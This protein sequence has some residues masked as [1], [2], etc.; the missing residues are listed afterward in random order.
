ML[1]KRESHN[2]ETLRGEELK[3]MDLPLD[4]FERVSK[5]ISRSGFCSRRDAEVFV[6]DGRV[7]VDG[8]LVDIGAIASYSSLIEIDGKPISKILNTRL[9]IF[10]KPVGLITTHKDENGR[11]T[12]FESLPKSMPRVISVGRLD[13]YSE[14]LMLLTNDTGLCNYLERSSYRRTYR[15][16]IKGRLSDRD[17]LELREGITID[18]INYSSI[19]ACNEYSNNYTS[20]ISISLYEGKNR[21]IRNIMYEFGY[22]ILRL[23]RL[24]YGPFDLQ[25]LRSGEIQELPSS[26]IKNALTRDSLEN[27]CY[28]KFAD[29]KDIMDRVSLGRKEIFMDKKPLK[30]DI[31]QDFFA[32]LNRPKAFNSVFKN[33]KFVDRRNN[34]TQNRKEDYM[35][36]NIG[37]KIDE[38]DIEN[39]EN[40]D[41]LET[42]SDSE[43]F[44]PSSESNDS[45]ERQES[46]ERRFSDRAPRSDSGEERAPRRDFGDRPQRDGERRFPP[47]EGGDRAP[48]RDFG[49]RPQR[50]GER[51]FPP[52]EGGSRFGSGGGGGGSRFGGGGGSRF[53][54]GGGDRGPR[55]DFG[56][57]APRDDSAPRTDSGEE[58][59]PR[60]D[61]GDRSQGDRPQRDGERRF[62]PR[63]GGGGSRFGSGG[64]SGSRFGGGGGSRFGS[65][66]GDRA[67]RRDFGPPRD[68]ERRF[69]PREGGGDDRAPRRDFGDRAPRTDS[70]EERAP[71]RDFGDRPQRDGERSFPPRDGGDRAPRRDFGDR[72]QRDG[73]RRFPPRVG[74]GGSRFGSGGGGGGSRF[75]G[76]GGSRFGSGGGDRGPRRDFGDRAPR[77]G[78]RSF[79]PRTDESGAS[80]DRVP[81]FV[82]EVR[83]EGVAR[84]EE[85]AKRVFPSDSD[86]A[87]RAKRHGLFGPKAQERRGRPDRDGGE[88]N[89][90]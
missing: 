47:R 68:G 66:G 33:R 2:R 44:A 51:R 69:P 57:R 10:Y 42:N 79:R 35:D 54:S 17:I 36:D 82:G 7:T 23:M 30:I 13:Q 11:R 62:P 12:V 48:R 70:G 86:D 74:G 60:R 4:R 45:G 31:D 20:I 81:S 50:D 27:I 75:G 56:D 26:F 9:W 77:D 38:N 72:P 84:L 83:K 80:S 22:V 19:D 18:G 76:G 25:G 73:E 6:E 43:N 88:S 14:G 65:G 49:D 61:F 32:N 52:R 41:F 37:N 89:L 8:F 64:G 3:V 90:S 39:H 1:A 34:F 55:R 15:V 40:E 5:I 24:S 71:R 21:E 16:W 78:E 58:R 59:A 63:V 29:A 46:D 67:P 53:G 85:R 87:N 28:G